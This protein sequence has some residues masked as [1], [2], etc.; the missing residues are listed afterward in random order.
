MIRLESSN[1]NPTDLFRRNAFN[2]AL[3]AKNLV[4][5]AEA[6]TRNATVAKTAIADIEL[7]VSLLEG[8]RVPGVAGEFTVAFPAPSAPEPD[9][10]PVTTID[11]A[12]L[13]RI[14]EV[15]TQ[16]E[17]IP[18]EEFKAK[19]KKLS[20]RPPGSGKMLWMGFD[21][22]QCHAPA[23]Q[24]CQSLGDNP[25]DIEKPHNPRKVLGDEK[26]KG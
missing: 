6:L 8:M 23:G 13:A 12:F 9:P 7:A 5:S 20:T 25:H 3:A 11:P 15:R 4:A 21:C 1:A 17:A 19:P 18:M 16:V 22:P 24:R 14:A 2:L 10:E 26:G